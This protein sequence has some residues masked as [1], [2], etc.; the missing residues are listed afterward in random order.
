ML[1]RNIQAN[2]IIQAGL[3]R[4]KSI[5]L[6]GDIV[7]PNPNQLVIII[8]GESMIRFVM[9]RIRKNFNWPKMFIYY[10]RNEDAM[11]T[12]IWQGVKPKKVKELEAKVKNGILEGDKK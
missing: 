6:L 4:L 5:G 8:T 9:K 11:I 1:S 2:K 7:Q 3:R 10:D 12:W